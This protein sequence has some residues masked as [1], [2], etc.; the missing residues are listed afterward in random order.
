MISA[1][2]RNGL[3]EDAKELASEFEAKY[4]KYD[5]V[6]LNTML[7]AYCRTGEMENVM[8]LMKKMDELSINPDRNTFHILIKYFVKEKLYMLAFKTLQDMHNRG[9]QLDEVCFRSFFFIF[10]FHMHL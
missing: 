5:V 2:C 3:L 6:I 4:E 7:C 9:Q 10:C 1:F 8:K